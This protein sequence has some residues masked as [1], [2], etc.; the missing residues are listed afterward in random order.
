MA[1]SYGWRIRE[2]YEVRDIP[3]HVERMAFQKHWIF[4]NMFIGI[5]DQAVGSYPWLEKMELIQPRSIISS[6]AMLEED[7]EEDLLENVFDVDLNFRCYVYNSSAVSRRIFWEDGTS[8]QV[9]ISD[10]PYPLKIFSAFQLSTQ[11][12]SQEIIEVVT[13]GHDF[14]SSP[15]ITTGRGA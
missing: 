6:I 3:K 2:M 1:R 4:W 7:R 15:E 14:T 5:L 10:V 12:R 9:R 11:Q 13:S 8:S